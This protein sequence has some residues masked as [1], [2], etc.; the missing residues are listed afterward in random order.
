MTKKISLVW[1]NSPIGETLYR[2]KSR[3]G[4]QRVAKPVGT[5]PRQR[6]AD[7]VCFPTEPEMRR[8]SDPE[9]AISW[10]GSR[11]FRPG[12]FWWPWAVAVQYSVSKLAF[13]VPVRQSA[14]LFFWPGFL[15]QSHTRALECFLPHVSCE[16][17]N[18]SLGI[19]P[20]NGFDYF[21]IVFIG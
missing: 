19:S 8:P 1:I 10:V 12:L 11:T 16:K 14:F 13:A 6:P 21:E 18:N 5:V 2:P 17:L 9:C 4:E 15:S 7:A 3:S 20:W